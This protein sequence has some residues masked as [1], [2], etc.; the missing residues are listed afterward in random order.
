MLRFDDER[1]TPTSIVPLDPDHSAP[2]YF[3][4]DSWQPTDKHDHRDRIFAIHSEK[5]DL[6]ELFPC[7]ESDDIANF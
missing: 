4:A 6:E 2:P 1:S 7:P 5:D 3:S